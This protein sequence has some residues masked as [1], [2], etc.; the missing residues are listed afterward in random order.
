MPIG[1]RSISHYNLAYYNSDDRTKMVGGDIG[2]FH[3]GQIV[4]EF[5]DAIADLQPGDIAGPVETLAGFHVIQLTEVNEPKQLLFEEVK[6]KIRQQQE[7]KKYD[8]L[9]AGW[10]AALKQQYGHDIFLSENN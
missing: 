2:Y 4:K 5:E 10:M 9:Y 3:T 7:K 1:T 6:V 8:T